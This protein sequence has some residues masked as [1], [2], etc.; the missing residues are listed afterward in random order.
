MRV[1]YIDSDAAERKR[2]Q[3]AAAQLPRIHSLEL[4]E[5]AEE[6]LLWAESHVADAAFMEIELPGMSGLE[7]AQKLTLSIPGIRIIF[8]TASPCYAL[9]AWQA[10]ASGY[11]LK[12]YEIAAIS[13][14]LDKCV[15][16]PLPSQRVQ[17]QTIPTFSVTVEGRPLSIPGEKLRELLA[18]L[19]ERG[20]RGITTGEGIA[21]LWPERPNDS[22]AKSLFRMTYKRLHDVLTQAGAGQILVS[23]DNRRFL[24]IDQ[25]DCDLYRILAGDSRAAQKYAGQYMTEYTWAEERNGQLH[26][27]L[28][29]KS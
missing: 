26:R 21:C 7:A 11:M 1:I 15:Y 14:E 20:E 5:S 4:F 9:A 2:F 17:I 3:F 19:V 8:V 13:K 23:R 25:V 18:L 6:A 27:M 12:P 16:H 28:L 10:D 24:Q 22:N 29:S